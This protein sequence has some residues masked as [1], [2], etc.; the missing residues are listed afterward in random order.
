LKRSCYICGGYD[1]GFSLPPG[2]K[3][4]RVD[5][6]GLAK[7]HKL[8]APTLRESMLDEAG[9]EIYVYRHPSCFLRVTTKDV[10]D[11]LMLNEEEAI[12]LHEFAE[13]FEV[14]EVR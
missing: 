4:V 3:N 5:M 1:K 10:I 8:E 6:E 14:K 13:A 9:N 7:S 12:K 11:G 2:M